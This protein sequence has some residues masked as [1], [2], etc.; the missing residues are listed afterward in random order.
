M[1]TRQLMV[2]LLQLMDCQI[3]KKLCLIYVQPTKLGTNQVSVD[4][5]MT[6]LKNVMVVLVLYNK[7]LVFANVITVLQQHKFAM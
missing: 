4:L 3:V 5:Q 2:Q 7:I 6:V 1:D